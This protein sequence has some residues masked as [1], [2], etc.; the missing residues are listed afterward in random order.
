[1]QQIV[2]KYIYIYNIGGVGGS[3]HRQASR[4]TGLESILLSAS[5]LNWKLYL[6]RVGLV[7]GLYFVWVLGGWILGEVGGVVGAGLV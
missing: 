6:Q 3:S 2:Y 1:M 5:W 7:S 4:T